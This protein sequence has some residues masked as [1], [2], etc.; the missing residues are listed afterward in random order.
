MKKIIL[1]YIVLFLGYLPVSSQ[2]NTFMQS[3]STNNKLNRI[4]VSPVYDGSDPSN[5][6]DIKGS[7]YMSTDFQVGTVNAIKENV[8]IRYNAF[9]DLFEI[10]QGTDS[11]LNLNKS[12]TNYV[13]K[14]SNYKFKSFAYSKDTKQEY[15]YFAFLTE[16]D[17][18]KT[19]LLKTMRKKLTKAQKA[20]NSYSQPKPASF[21]SNTIDNYYIL[22]KNQEII[23]FKPKSKILYT[24]FP[25]IKT[26]L[27]NYI[28]DKNIDLKTEEDL[29]KTF[30]YIN[31]LN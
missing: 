12:N 9:N 6:K 2:N 23:D 31:T 13:V 14:L 3:S 5:L 27:K 30:E 1:F 17:S 10:K 15:S 11:I 19:V 21:S 28:K 16:L 4:L 24:L 29:I 26:E 22:N 25:N 8:L 18:T 20:T 7:P